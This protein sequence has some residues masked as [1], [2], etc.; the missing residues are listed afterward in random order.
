[1]TALTPTEEQ[2][3]DAMR[4]SLIDGTSVRAMIAV[5][6]APFD[7]CGREGIALAWPEVMAQA[8]GS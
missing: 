3:L 1:M 4:A 6:N 2:A 8:L 5:E 7:L